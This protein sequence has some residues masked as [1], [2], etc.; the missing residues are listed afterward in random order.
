[1]SGL[2]IFLAPIAA[3]LAADFWVAKRRHID[4]PALYRRHGRY[5]YNAAG[6]NWRAVVAFL[7][8]LVPNLPGMAA[9]VT[10]SLTKGV[11]GA[12]YIYDMFYIWGFSSAFLVYSV[13]SYFFPARETLVEK[14]IHDDTETIDGVGYINDGVHTPVETGIVDDDEKRVM[15]GRE[16]SV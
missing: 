4:V 6:T 11:G 2:G 9:S 7:V 10:P 5:R 8:S 16:D 3:I 1:M 14:T 12:E 13:L 15:K